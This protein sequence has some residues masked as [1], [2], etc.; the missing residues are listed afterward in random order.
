MRLTRARQQDQDAA[1]RPTA[2]DPSADRAAPTQEVE[3]IDETWADW[4]K[5]D[6]LTA[7]MANREDI[8][9][10]AESFGKLAGDNALVIAMAVRTLP[11]RQQLVGQIWGTVGAVALRLAF[12]A[13]AT[14]FRTALT[15]LPTVRMAAMAI[16]EATGPGGHRVCGFGVQRRYRRDA[17]AC[18]VPL[19]SGNG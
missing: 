10:G 12:I 2:D 11:R 15:L 1:D 9:L 18:T 7:L 16:N 14:L 19:I 13:V 8:F 4:Q 6:L 5:A 17:G 3:A